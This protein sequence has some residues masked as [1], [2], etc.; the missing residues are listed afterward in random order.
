MDEIN[1]FESNEFKLNER[2][3]MFYT[4]SYILFFSKIIII[5]FF[6]YFPCN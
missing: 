6:F 4:N 5:G 1:S 3:H 2:Y